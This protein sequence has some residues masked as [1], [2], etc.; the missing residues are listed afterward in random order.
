MTTAASLAVPGAFPARSAAQAKLA[1]DESEARQ[2]ASPVRAVAAMRY[3]AADPAACIVAAYPGRIRPFPLF[4]GAV[5]LLAMASADVRVARDLVA[6]TVTAG[7]AAG[8]LVAAS[9]FLL[10][11]WAAVHPM[12]SRLRGSVGIAVDAPGITIS[13]RRLR[14]RTGSGLLP[15]TA[16]AQVRLYTLMTRDTGESPATTRFRPVVQLNRHDGTCERWIGP[17]E[18]EHY[19][20]E[21]LVAAVRRFAPGVLVVPDGGSY[22]DAYEAAPIAVL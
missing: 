20:P 14:R 1:G 11:I 21:Q 4:L 5:A 15:W 18:F 12:I 13:S 22:D 10:V 9:T 17:A 6:G 16:I 7:T 3:E 19:D 2:R 8:E